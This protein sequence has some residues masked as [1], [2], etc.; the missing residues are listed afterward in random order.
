MVVPTLENRIAASCRGKDLGTCHKLGNGSYFVHFWST[1][2]CDQVA[3]E[4]FWLYDIQREEQLSKAAARALWSKLCREG[5]ERT[6][7]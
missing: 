6:E 2:S 5:Y 4:Y 7:S 3:V 1:E